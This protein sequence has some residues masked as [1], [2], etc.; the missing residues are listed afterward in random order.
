MRRALPTSWQCLSAPLRVGS[1]ACGLEARAR[2]PA[3]PQVGE[4]PVQ[5][6][7]HVCFLQAASELEMLLIIRMGFRSGHLQYLI[8]CLLIL[9]HVFSRHTEWGLN[10]AQ[11]LKCHSRVTSRFL[12]KIGACLGPPTQRPHT[13]SP[14]YVALPA[15]RCCSEAQVCLLLRRPCKAAGE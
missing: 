8:M 5:D 12:S 7:A 14:C 11:R 10:P 6:S 4:L 1:S 15:H 3:I 13:G 9:F 2:A